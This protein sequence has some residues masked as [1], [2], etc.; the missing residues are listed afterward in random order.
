M[1]NSTAVLSHLGDRHVLRPYGIFGGEAGTLAES[2]LYRGNEAIPLH[3][4]D[5]REIK[6]GD[7]LCF[8]LSGAGGYGPAA[9]R[10][11]EAIERDLADGYITLKAA[12]GDYGYDT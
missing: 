6:K 8:K 9:E 7:V 12:Q 5:V 11:R 2:T 4:K 3:S 1:L 10:T